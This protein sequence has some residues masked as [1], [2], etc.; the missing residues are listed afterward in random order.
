MD[1]SKDAAL[2]M[3]GRTVV[4]FQRLEHN[5]KL[6][7]RLGPL[8][9]T[10]QKVQKDIAK[11][12]ERA[13]TLTM[14]QAIQ[15]WLDYCYEQPA[16]HYGTPDLF[17]VSV[18]MTFALESDPESQTRQAKALRDLLEVRNDLIHSRLAKFEWEMPEACDGLIEELEQVNGK[19]FD[20][21]V[22]MVE[23]DRRCDA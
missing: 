8:Q 18:Q 11:R 7:A 13:A 14:G 23:R 20:N 4:N 5:L 2:R 19:H 3:L 12:H 1:T 22:R 15:A 21:H 9:G 6:A 16:T 10:I 17:D